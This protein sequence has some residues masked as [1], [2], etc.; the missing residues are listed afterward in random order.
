[1]LT[2][3]LTASTVSDTLSPHFPTAEVLVTIYLDTSSTPGTQ[4]IRIRV[5]KHSQ[6]STRSVP[7]TVG[8][9]PGDI[10]HIVR[11]ESCSLI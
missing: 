4:S 7:L 10:Q 5:K 2:N 9:G 6:Y 1:M 11:E 3:K 8:W